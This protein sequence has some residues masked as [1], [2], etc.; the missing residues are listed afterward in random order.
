MQPSLL[1]IVVILFFSCAQEIKISGPEK[2]Q[3]ISFKRTAGRIPVIG[4]TLNGKS[5]Y[6]II[7]TGASISVLNEQEAESFG[8]IIDTDDDLYVMGS[9]ALQI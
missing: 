7:D 6:F 3:S 5:A 9:Q 1:L 2:N 4:A 8:F